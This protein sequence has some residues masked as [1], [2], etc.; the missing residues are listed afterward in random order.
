MLAM[1]TI[2]GRVIRARTSFYDV[3]DGGAV[4]RCQLRGRVKRAQRSA[5]GRQIYAD[6]V[7]VGDEVLVT[8]LENEEGVIE[9]ILPRR[10]KFSRRYPGK[11]D[12]I[13]Q[14][15]VANANQVG[16]VL[17]TRLPDL[18]LRFLDRFLILAE[19]GEME[20]VVCLNKVDLIDSLE[21]RKLGAIL[22][23][24]EELG[25]PVIFT[26]I[27]QPQSIEP[28][29]D[30]LRD[31][32]SVI[33]GASGVGK[34]SLLNAVQPGLGL[35]VGEVGLKTGKGRHTTTLVE[36]FWL[37]FGGEVADTPGIREVGLWGVDT[38]NLDLYF[39]EMERYLGEC[40]YADCI[41]ISEP[42]C[43][44]TDAVNAGE[45]SDV[46]YLSYV[47]LRSEEKRED[48]TLMP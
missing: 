7:A 32:F 36:L 23:A 47:S 31:K 1:G 21:Q 10:T 2:Q 6:P 34:S 12:A 33:V 22:S 39:P 17:S 40:K 44:V 24:Y 29:R 35:R 4:L 13:E 45:I 38:E 30:A 42:G 5:E 48:S 37:D 41:H 18:N 19:V 9:E 43:A 14:I 20:A 25:Y 8:P 11:R 16:I 26:S 46:R 27:H 28:F 3:Q 15:V